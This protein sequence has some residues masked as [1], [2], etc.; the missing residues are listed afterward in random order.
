MSASPLDFVGLKETPKQRR[1]VSDVPFLKGE[2]IMKHFVCVAV[3][4]LVFVGYMQSA[5][6][7]TIVTITEHNGGFCSA[8]FSP[9][10][11]KIPC[12]LL[13]FTRGIE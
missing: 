11:T 5:E 10:G 12:D 6:I 2:D 4:L 7:P 9:D 1:M 3:V 8:A 13:A